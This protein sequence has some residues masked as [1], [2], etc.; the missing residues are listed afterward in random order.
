MASSLDT[1]LGDACSTAGCSSDACFVDSQR[2]EHK[3]CLVH[4]YASQSM[5][6]RVT[7][8]DAVA[9]QRGLM[10]LLWAEAF[11]ECAV[12]LGTA[13]AAQL[14]AVERS[15]DPLATLLGES[16]ARAAATREIEAE[17]RP[18][19]RKPPS[20]GDVQRKKPELMRFD[21]TADALGLTK[22][23]KTVP[24]LAW[25]TSRDAPD[26]P[27][28]D[29]HIGFVRG[30]PCGNCASAET[31]L[32]AIGGGNVHAGKVE[33]WGSKDAPDSLYRLTCLACQHTTTLD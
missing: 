10:D 21:K 2:R 18:R 7:S 6:W 4:F 33:T 30:P 29:A 28:A 15:D 16:D 17:K 19:A 12:E 20:R 32:V 1:F 3:A 11:A 22:S 8:A 25:A 5:R 26:F 24:T 9:D 13:A 14:I 23:K 27:P 31:S